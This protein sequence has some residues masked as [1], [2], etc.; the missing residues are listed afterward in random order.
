MT[1]PAPYTKPRGVIVADASALINL[2]RPVS[3][4]A[5]ANDITPS[6]YINFLLMLSQKGYQILIPEMVSIEAAE[7]LA[8]GQ[9][10]G[11][12]FNSSRKFGQTILKPFIQDASLP[13]GDLKKEYPGMAILA[14]TGPPAVDTFCKKLAHAADLKQF[15]PDPYV[16]YDAQQR[17][18]HRRAKVEE[19]SKQNTSDFG[20][21]AIISFMQDAV[22]ISDGVPIIVLTDDGGLLKRVKDQFGSYHTMTSEQ[23][24]SYMHT[25]G[26][27]PHVGISS[28]ILGGL[29]TI[30]YLSHC[31]DGNS[32]RPSP[33]DNHDREGRAPSDFYQ[34]MMQLGAELGTR[35]PEAPEDRPGQ[36]SAAFKAKYKL[37]DRIEP[38]KPYSGGR[39]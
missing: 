27:A 10:V 5:R 11:N 4:Y 2:C 28:D 12:L 8:N 17:H 26:L 25:A 32:N 15:K 37:G 6:Y 20:D 16:R 39:G 14:K 7:V 36:R 21:D 13:L 9:S 23:L 34:S 33:V 29:L 38:P 31:H 22:P 19:I 1:T 35:R 30:D 3:P 18:I 24:I